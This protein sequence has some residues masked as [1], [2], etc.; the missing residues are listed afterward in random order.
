M[1]DYDKDAALVA[2]ADKTWKKTSMVL[3]RTAR[4][5]EFTVCDAVLA[6]LALGI[7]REVAA[8]RLESQGNLEQW[9]HSEVRLKGQGA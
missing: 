9:M 3:V 8:G 4:A 2:S 1:P 5:L 6:E 7:P